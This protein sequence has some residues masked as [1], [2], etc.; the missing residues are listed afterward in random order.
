[1]D[2]VLNTQPPLQ[3][4]GIHSAPFSESTSSVLCQH[5]STSIP[6]AS[7]STVGQSWE[8]IAQQTPETVLE[9]PI[10]SHEPPTPI[11]IG[12]LTQTPTTLNDQPSPTSAEHILDK[13]YDDQP[14]H[15]RKKRRRSMSKVDSRL[16][17]GDPL[18]PT[19]ITMKDLCGDTSFGRVS[20][21]HVQIQE[22][23][24]RARRDERQRRAQIMNIREAKEKRGDDIDD[25][26]NSSNFHTTSQYLP[27]I[28]D[29][30][31]KHIVSNF[32]ETLKTSHF[33][34]SMRMNAAGQLVLDEE[35]LT[36]DRS[37]NPEIL[38]NEASMEHVEETDISRFV[39]S[40]THSRKLKGNR[41]TRGETDLFF[42][43]GAH[44]RIVRPFEL[45]AAIS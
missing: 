29:N 18:D 36:V 13:R 8:Y 45:S 26:D 42:E 23:H 43:V 38:Q 30:T 5:L 34:V 33:S 19:S 15:T 44:F 21:R 11:P 9:S 2:E 25:P 28:T 22:A 12:L 41:W 10:R 3:S 39:N 37:A 17:P 16:H 6:D 7:L 35:S 1:M 27:T 40:A 20:S 24:S 31:D 32:D 4:L 14:T